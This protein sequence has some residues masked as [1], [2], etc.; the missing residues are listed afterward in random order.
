MRGRLQ[1]GSDFD[2]NRSNVSRGFD[3]NYMEV[4]SPAFNGSNFGGNKKVKLKVKRDHSGLKID[5]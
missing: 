2:D 5:L 4:G 1:S 3:D